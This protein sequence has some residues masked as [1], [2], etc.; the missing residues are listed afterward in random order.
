M[1]LTKEQRIELLARAREAKARKRLQNKGDEVPLPISEADEE[2]EEEEEEPEPE[3]VPE[4]VPV[5][6]KKTLPI[7]WL[8]KP[9]L[10]VKV[11]CKEKLT[12]EAPVIDD[13]PQVV[14]D[15]I[16][17]PPKSIIKK[18]KAVRAST[19][20]LDIAEPAPIEEVLEEVK[21]NDMKYRPQRRMPQEEPRIPQHPVR[22]IK[23]EP[24]LSLFNY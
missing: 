4:P 9:E 20:T 16:V 7:K 8:K 14:A 3:P 18:P 10:P 12:K 23:Q 13:E 6:K 11:C 19:R 21:N 24:P 17:I 22:I 1:V 5:P 15:N 2:A